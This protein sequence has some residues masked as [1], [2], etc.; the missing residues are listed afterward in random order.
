MSSLEHACA[1]TA[2]KAS[3]YCWGRNDHGQLGTGTSTNSN[4]KPT[5]SPVKTAL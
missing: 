1:V 4:T 3:V 5:K 2:D